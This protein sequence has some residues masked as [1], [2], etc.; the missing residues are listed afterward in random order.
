MH[1]H[2]HRAL[3]RFDLCREPRPDT[4]CQQRVMVRGAPLE[5]AAEGGFE[6]G[7]RFSYKFA[8]LRSAMI[9]IATVVIYPV[10]NVRTLP[11]FVVEVVVVG[12]RVHVAV[13]DVEPLAGFADPADI[14]ATFGPLQ[15]RYTAQVP[16]DPELPDWFREICSPVHLLGKAT[17]SELSVYE[18]AFQ[19]YLETYLARYVNP[20]PAAA[21]AV[22]APA[23]LSYK[24]H[25]YR[26]SPAKKVM[27]RFDDDWFEI[28][29]GHYHFGPLLFEAEPLSDRLRVET[30]PR[31]RALEARP[32]M[33]FHQRSPDSESD[34]ARVLL[35]L[36]TAHAQL[37]PP[38]M[39]QLRQSGDCPA[40]FLR[41]LSQR[42]RA[43]LA[44]IGQDL[45]ALQVDPVVESSGLQPA[46]AL[47][48]VEHKE[49]A[50]GVLYVLE[51]ST[52]G[53][54]SLAG[55][56]QRRGWR[57]EVLG[58]YRAC[59]EEPVAGWEAFRT[60]LNTVPLAHEP[61]IDAARG[62]FCALDALFARVAEMPLPGTPLQ[63]LP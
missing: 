26:H 44:R 30:G 5:I 4:Y 9:D 54:A 25:H 52:R 3:A 56:M 53:A 19:I 20:A 35:G 28:F 8:R 40:E 6:A 29:L 41:D 33:R 55:V 22:E 49:A 38:A 16:N 47:P 14:P 43:R 62:L 36:Y 11:V 37:E 59:A 32:L 31:H 15:A 12:E 1:A 18:D 10:E 27:S 21:E 46:G 39:E 57:P 17:L 42:Q 58:Y 63:A 13:I 45:Q 50:W 7:R 61:V 2:L 24:R 23:V 51:G 60:V 48:S 34:Y